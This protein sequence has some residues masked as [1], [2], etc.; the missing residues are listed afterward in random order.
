MFKNVSPQFILNDIN[1]MYILFLDL[2]PICLEYTKNNMSYGIPTFLFTSILNLNNIV[3][4]YTS[5][6]INLL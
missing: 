5:Y 3:N 2:T 6:Y 1:I 4:L